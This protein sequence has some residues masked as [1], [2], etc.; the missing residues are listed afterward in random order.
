MRAIN[1][2]SRGLLGKEHGLPSS[3]QITSIC[4]HGIILSAPQLEPKAAWRL[5]CVFRD[6]GAHLD[7]R[8][9][10]LLILL[11]AHPSGQE[12]IID[13]ALAGLAC[14]TMSVILQARYTN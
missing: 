6:V 8:R 14:Y 13:D 5:K 9:T 2:K 1:A 3:T 4:N 11:R 10:V 7:D 12:N